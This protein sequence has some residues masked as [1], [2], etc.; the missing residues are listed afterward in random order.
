MKSIHKLW[1]EFNFGLDGILHQGVGSFSLQAYL[2]IRRVAKTYNRYFFE[3][4][5][6]N[7]TKILNLSVGINEI[8]YKICI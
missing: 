4:V 2:F 3:R 1:R 7:Y 5:K 8:L 6:M